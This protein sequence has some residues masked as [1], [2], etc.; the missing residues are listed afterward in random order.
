MPDIFSGQFCVFS[1]HKNV[2][3]KVKSTGEMSDASCPTNRFCFVDSFTHETWEV[4][5]GYY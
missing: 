2:Q 5:N 1:L 3:L 4:S